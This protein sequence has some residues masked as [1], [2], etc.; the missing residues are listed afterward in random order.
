MPKDGF[1]EIST[2]KAAGGQR[3]LK[4]TDHDKERGSNVTSARIP[5]NGA[6]AFV[7]RGRI[8][9]VKGRGVGIYVRFLNARREIIN[10]PDLQAAKLAVCV[11]TGAEGKWEAF[12]MPFHTTPETAA[13]QVWIHSANAADVEAYLDDLEIVKAEPK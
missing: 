4:I 3:S 5:V 11:P 10:M 7:L 2:E 9:H 8:H 13:I 6:A 1:A 12:A